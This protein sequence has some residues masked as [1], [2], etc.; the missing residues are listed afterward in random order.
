[1]EDRIGTIQY[2]TI[3]YNTIAEKMTLV[4]VE[5][6]NAIKLNNAMQYNTIQYKKS[7]KWKYS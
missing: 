1:M 2:N 5:S 7:E 6:D 4:S 3:Q